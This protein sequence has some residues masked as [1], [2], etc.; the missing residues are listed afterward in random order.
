MVYAVSYHPLSRT[1]DL[2]KI[3]FADSKQL[4]EEERDALFEQ[5]EKESDWIGWGVSVCSPQDIS[6]SMLAK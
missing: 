1:N 6:S 3:G 2:K 4:K 5:I